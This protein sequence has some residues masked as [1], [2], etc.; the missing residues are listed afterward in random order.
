MK[1]TYIIAAT[2]LAALTSLQ[3]YLPQ[4]QSFFHQ[5]FQHQ[6]C[7]GIFP[8]ND[9]K[10]PDS[11]LFATN[12]IEFDEVMDRVERVYGPIISKEGARLN[13]I[14]SWTNDQVNAR[15]FR[16]GRTW[17]I[18]M[19]GGLAR[20]TETTS[21]SLALVACHEIG[22]H[23]GGAPKR[24]SFFGNWASNE[25]QSDYFGSLKCMRKLFTDEEN[26]EY[27]RTHSIDPE[28][29]NRC[30]QNFST[31]EERAICM[32]SSMA[33]LALGLLAQDLKKET[34]RPEFTT[35]DQNKVSRTDHRHPATQCR[36]DT[37]FAGALCNVPHSVEVAQDDPELGAC[38]RKQNH[39]DGL[40]SRCWY[41]P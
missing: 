19:F 32:R 38:T 35:P 27:V 2:A 29:E 37:Y 7:E 5:L 8:K 6:L 23:I 26:L 33:G 13:V 34:T 3:T 12:K 15:A 14:R 36:V 31:R 28:V 11:P 20:H 22:H 17:N 25:G 24:S 10:I 9:L 39:Q 1:L 16:S 18:E 21:D 41:R 4:T 30:R 40:R